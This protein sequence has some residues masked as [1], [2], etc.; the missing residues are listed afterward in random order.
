MTPR[1]PH[2]FGS[3]TKTTHS[4][5]W[6]YLQEIPLAFY[7]PGIFSRRGPVR[8]DRE[9]TL[10]DIAPT[11]AELLGVDFPD[12]RP[13]QP[14]R[15]ALLPGAKLPRL[16]VVVVW[17]GGGWNLLNE[18]PRAWP[19]LKSLMRNGTSISNAEVGSSPSVTPA[20]HATIG[21]G[22][23]PQQHGV[24]DIW[25]RRRDD[26]GGSHANVDPSLIRVE[27]FADSYDRSVDNEAKIGLI[28]KD[29]WHLWMMGQGAAAVGGDKDIG[30]VEN[31]EGEQITNRNV[32]K[33][34]GYLAGVP[35]LQADVA[36]LDRADGTADGRWRENAVLALDDPAALR[37]TPA[38]MLYQTRQLK[39]MVER[40]G[41]G[42]DAI[43]DLLFTNYKPVDDVGH[44]YS[45]MSPEQEDTI[46]FADA[47]LESFVSFLNAEVG[48][49]KWAMV[50]TADHGQ[51]PPPA[52]TGAWGLDVDR[53]R[54]YA[55]EVVGGDG[56]VFDSWRPTGYWLDPELPNRDAASVAISNGLAG[57]T[58]A[59]D[60][61]GDELPET[62]TG[63]PDDRLFESVFP[64]SRI[65]S[66]L[67]CA[68]DNG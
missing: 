50:V 3:P 20:T 24:V 11:L 60:A 30:V 45:M 2:L 8:V 46:E 28:A 13:G 9:V 19:F 47:A 53:V 7:G 26:T 57:Y 5:P 65:D 6:D 40:E 52:Q 15:E 37:V 63:Q 34:P 56:S 33:M 58:V 22:A 4:G 67:K 41:F 36:T 51:G 10:A 25:V 17:D 42:D 23:Y 61:R 54:S 66:L 32:Y 14:V 64:T 68:A 21:T 27:T 48:K 31:E 38:R 44:T 1:A 43:A 55:E 29:G 16:V 59:D 62:F 49:K 39:E 18:Y 12:D 35:G